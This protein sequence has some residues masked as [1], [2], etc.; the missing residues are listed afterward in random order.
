MPSK[1][2]SSPSSK[3]KGATNAE[4][5]EKLD[6]AAMLDTEET[7]IVDYL[8]EEGRIRE[9]DS[10]R[11]AKRAKTD[12]SAPG[13]GGGEDGDGADED[14]DYLGS[15]LHGEEGEVD[16][17]MLIQLLLKTH[18]QVAEAAAASAKAAPAAKAKAAAKKDGENTD[19]N[20]SSAAPALTPEQESLEYLLR[21]TKH[22]DYVLQQQSAWEKGQGK[23][24]LIFLGGGLR[25]WRG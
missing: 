16:R 11:D 1:M 24:N 9:E 2:A 21:E 18:Q 5:V 7:D 8:Q 4:P 3:S 12:G 19:G 13:D 22:A 14:D 15:I 6:L 20:G 10:Q 17:N 23:S 25:W